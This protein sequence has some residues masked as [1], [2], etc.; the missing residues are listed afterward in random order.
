MFDFVISPIAIGIL[1][2]ILT[3]IKSKSI[4]NGFG[5]GISGGILTFIVQFSVFLTSNNGEDYA[6]YNWGLVY[7]TN[8]LGFFTILFSF[9]IPGLAIGLGCFLCYKVFRKRF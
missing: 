1:V 3:L 2:L 8:E 7:D 9:I 6:K 4:K 5:L